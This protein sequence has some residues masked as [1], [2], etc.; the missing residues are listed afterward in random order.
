MQIN[1]I[2]LATMDHLNRRV[3][4]AVMAGVLILLLVFTGFNLIYG[5]RYY[6]EKAG[7]QKK[8]A[9]LQ[10]T[11]PENVTFD[12][13][14][15]DIKDLPVK[16]RF[17]NRLIAEDRFPWI[18]ILDVIERTLP[19]GVILR[20]FQPSGD[21][22][23]LSLTGNANNVNEMVRFHKALEG[24]GLFQY[25]NLS[26]LSL[27]QPGNVGNQVR[28]IQFEVKGRFRIESLFAGAEGSAIETALQRRSEK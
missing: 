12:L 28:G 13:S 24:S 3:I 7:Y 1:T 6:R 27:D 15:K 5:I 20:R 26:T 17:S 10:K 2:N 8:I 19:P 14:E 25:V 11:L 22:L 4:T 18:Q 23:N 21:F 9:R 16:V